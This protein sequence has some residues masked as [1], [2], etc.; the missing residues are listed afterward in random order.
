[1]IRKEIFISRKFIVALSMIITLVTII[2][3]NAVFGGYVIFYEFGFLPVLTLILGPYGAV[4]FILIEIPYWIISLGETNITGMLINVVLIIIIGILPWKLWYSIYPKQPVEVLNINRLANF[5]KLA[6]IL[7]VFILQYFFFFDTNFQMFASDTVSME[8]GNI[9]SGVIL[10]L[11]GI[12]IWNRYELPYFTPNTQLKGIMPDYIYDIFLLIAL[13]IEA[14]TLLSFY[15]KNTYL[16][17]AVL[18]IIIIFIFKPFNEDVFKLNKTLK[19]NMFSK[20]TIS[21]FAVMVIISAILSTISV[22]AMMGGIDLG[23]FVFEFLESFLRLLLIFILLLIIYMLFLEKRVVKPI[24]QLS[25]YLSKDISNLKNN[26]DLNDYLKNIKG[27]NEVKSLSESLVN[28]ENELYD[29]S[30]NLIQLTKETERFE[31]ELNLAHEIQNSM[32]PTDFDEFS[33]DKNISLWGSMK[34]AREVGGDFYDYFKIDEENIGFVIGDVSGKGVTAALIMVKAMTSI[35]DFSNEYDDLS[36]AFFRINNELCKGN[37]EELFVTCWL[38]KL[39]IKTGELSYVNAGHNNPLI[40]QDNG[41][42]KYLETEHDLVL[43][44]MEDMP[45]EKHTIQLKPGDSLFLYTDG[46]TEANIDYNG[47]YGEERLENI[48]NSHKD[49]DLDNIIKSIDEDI[50]DFYNGGDLFDDTTMFVIRFGK[51]N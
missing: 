42:F 12:I 40:K 48:L 35:Q 5:V 34:A 19:L 25:R 10:L 24:Q 38:G 27:N 6:I 36:E 28:M 49:D 14:G 18:L 32:I 15:P 47:F 26:K 22:I 41:D 3:E 23:L 1:M 9:A 37:V 8:Y 2:L 51:Q 13:I 30:Q 31:T 33:K 20:V 21:I 39:N 4:G 44:V 43:A 7:A 16:S 11:I 45:Y 29:Y 17:F 46:V 50:N